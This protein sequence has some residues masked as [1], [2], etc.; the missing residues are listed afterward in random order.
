MHN[1]WLIARHEYRKMTGTRT[2]LA[3]TIGVPLLIVVDIGI[4]IL[5]GFVGRDDQPIG[6]R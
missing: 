2:F 4:G 5:A 6:I 3:T 1:F